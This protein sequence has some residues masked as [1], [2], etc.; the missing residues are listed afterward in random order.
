MLFAAGFGT[1]MRHLTEDRPKPLIEVAGVPLIDHT[2][3]LAKGIAPN[4]IVAN[5]HYKPEALAAHLKGQGVEAILETPTILETGGGLKNALPRLGPGPVFTANTDA[6]WK[7]PNPFACL[8]DVWNPEI[9]DAL[10]LCVPRE[11]A[12]G[13]IGS[14]DFIADPDGRLQRGPGAIYGGIQVLKTDRLAEIGDPAFSLNLLWSK[15]LNDG[16]L[17]GTTYP[18]DWCDVGSPEGIPLAESLLETKDV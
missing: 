2:L 13:H 4:K 15:M 11:R 9:M 16:R 5:L 17:F 6:I 18:G 1:R 3:K 12:L 8:L 14:G 10:L 7:G